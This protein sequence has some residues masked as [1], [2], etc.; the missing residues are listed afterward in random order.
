MWIRCGNRDAE[1]KGGIVVGANSLVAMAVPTTRSES[2]GLKTAATRCTASEPVHVR[3]LADGFDFAGL[4]G[5][6]CGGIL[7]PLK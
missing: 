2:R 5:F 6:D 1:Y 3:D 7:C 4:R